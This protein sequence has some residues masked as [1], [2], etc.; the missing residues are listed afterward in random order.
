MTCPFC[1]EFILV[2]FNKC[3]CDPDRQ[4]LA[5]Q[6]QREKEKKEKK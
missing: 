2:P 3:R 1:H 5:W 4:K 6:R